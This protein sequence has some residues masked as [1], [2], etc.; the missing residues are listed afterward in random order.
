MLTNF[1]E[2]GTINLPARPYKTRL[3]FEGPLGDFITSFLTYKRTKKRL[4]KIRLDCF[5]RQLQPFYSY[6]CKHQINTIQA[7]NL[8]VLLQ[9]I[10]QLPPQTTIVYQ[11]LSTLRV[12]MQYAFEQ[13]LLPIDYSRK[14]PHCKRSHQA[15]LPSVYSDQEVE[16]LIA[17]VDRSTRTGKRNY[18]IILLAARLGLRASD[19][20]HLRFEHLHWE[21]CM[22]RLR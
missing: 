13:Q 22:I 10:G 4:S 6:C 3:T 16:K 8:E 9:Y 21:D 17:A 5:Y 11:T 19:I 7:I 18:A 15:K 14:L 12:L 1:S 2:R 20:I